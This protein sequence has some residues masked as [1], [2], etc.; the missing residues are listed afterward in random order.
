MMIRKFLSKD[1]DTVM[2]IWLQGNLDAHPFISRDY[3]FKNLPTVRAA[4]QEANVYCYVDS[5]DHVQG[6]IGLQNDYIAGIFV[7]RQARGHGVGTS[8]LNYV[9]ASRQKLALDVY[10]K[11]QHALN[12]YQ[13]HGFVITKQSDT[14]A[15]MV[16]QAKINL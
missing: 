1:I 10:L 2:G 16:W 13:D 4:I 11:N 15:Q 14:E 12:F 5:S 9:K 3:W 7:T 8:L 6:F